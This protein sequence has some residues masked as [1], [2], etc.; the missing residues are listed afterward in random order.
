M[1]RAFT[2]T[3]YWLRWLAGSLAG[4]VVVPSAISTDRSLAHNSHHSTS[5]VASS[6][7]DEWHLLCILTSKRAENAPFNA[8]TY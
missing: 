5:Y 3:T 6:Y 1:L 8:G 4:V 7:W 2:T